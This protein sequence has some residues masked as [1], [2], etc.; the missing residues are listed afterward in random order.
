[1]EIGKKAVKYLQSQLILPSVVDP[2]CI[3]ASHDI[4]YTLGHD[5]M[6]DTC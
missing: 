1:M 6:T 4:P 5:L 2:E 3:I